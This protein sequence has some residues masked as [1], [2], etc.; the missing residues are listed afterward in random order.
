M[1]SKT[2]NIVKDEEICSVGDRKKSKRFVEHEKLI[3][4]KV[5]S[6]KTK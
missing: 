4:R 1:D 6:K 2:E 3:E 5:R